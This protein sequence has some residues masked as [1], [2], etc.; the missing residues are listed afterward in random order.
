MKAIQ[1]TVDEDLL[2]RLDEDEEVQRKGR[3]AFLR[4]AAVEYLERKR[5][6]AI[7]EAYESA[8]GDDGMSEDELEGWEQEGT[9]PDDP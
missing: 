6:Q 1:I 5:R 9:W 4:K 2:R 7:A 3:S 8:Y